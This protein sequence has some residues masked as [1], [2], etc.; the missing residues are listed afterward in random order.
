[1]ATRPLQD[2]NEGDQVKKKQRRENET[3]SK[4]RKEDV[5][6]SFAPL[7]VNC[8]VQILSYLCE[9]GLNSIAECSRDCYDIRNSKPLTQARTGTLLWTTKSTIFSLKHKL[10]EL[11]VIFTGNR[12]TLRIKG[13]AESM[14]SNDHTPIIAVEPIPLKAIKS[15]DCSS[16]EVIPVNQGSNLSSL[17]LLSFNLRGLE[18]LDLSN[19][20]AS[21][22]DY[23]TRNVVRPFA[24]RCKS[25]KSI[26]WKGCNQ[27]S[28]LASEFKGFSSLTELYLEN[29]V[30]APAHFTAPLPS[31][32]DYLL[33][34]CK[35]LDKLCLKGAKVKL[36]AAG[37]TPITQGILRRTV[38]AHENLRWVRADFSYETI[39]FLQLFCPNVKCIGSSG[40]I[41]TIE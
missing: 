23:T 41:E 11:N 16:A 20:T 38:R 29:V 40:G 30:F 39:L 24:R 26:R 28:F 35:C 36:G 33:M 32:D 14:K 19:I 6:P 2:G 8:V 15:L 21:E 27:L 17:R 1:M 5:S 13:I 25:I 37:P 4:E 7:N 12:S 3:I 22:D 34:N 9:E 31:N 10:E 18:H